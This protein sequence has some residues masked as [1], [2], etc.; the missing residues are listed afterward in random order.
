MVRLTLA[1]N[2][3]MKIATRIALLQWQA[4]PADP[5]NPWRLILA[6]ITPGMRE[7]AGEEKVGGRMDQEIPH[8]RGNAVAVGKASAAALLSAL[9]DLMERHPTA[10][11]GTSRLPAPKQAMKAAIKEMW[12]QEPGFR[13]QLMRA[14]LY[15][16]H[17]QDGI[18][19]TVLDSKLPEIR[20]GADGTPDLEALRQQ[21]I[22]LSG[23]KGENFRQWIYWSKVSLAEMEILSE[24]WRAFEDRACDE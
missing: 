24:E 19:D 9:G 7:A 12:R 23:S 6:W 16:S 11:M 15:L 20:R 21:A 3:E 8:A 5:T 4:N 22:D 2:F 10:L 17:F 1:G 18:G 13:P 14:Y